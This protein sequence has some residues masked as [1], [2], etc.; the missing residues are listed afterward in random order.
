M[1]KSI[2][3]TIMEM[4][5]VEA[6]ML[7]YVGYNEETQVL[8]IEFCRGPVHVYND[9]PK[10]IFEGLLLSPAVDDYFNENIRNSFKNRR[11]N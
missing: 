1:K 10:T 3:G 2:D 9:V 6:K 4:T 7:S 5:F 11:V 8:A